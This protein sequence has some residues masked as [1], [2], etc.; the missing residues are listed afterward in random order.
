MSNTQLIMLLANIPV[1]GV[2]IYAAANFRKFE[3]ELRIFSGF[4]FANMLI[5]VVSS[6]MNLLSINNLPLLHIYTFC[7]GLSLL[8]FYHFI[9]RKYV[10]SSIL[11]WL[12]VAYALF[13]VLDSLFFEDLFTFNSLALTVL[14]VLIIILS[15]STFN[16]FLID[17][18]KAEQRE[19]INGL[20]WINSGLF[21]YFST[22]L[23]LYYFGDQLMDALFPADVGRMAWIP[24]MFFIVIMYICF[25]I[26]LW[27]SRKQ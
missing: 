7:T 9:L 20:L 11:A 1:A 3:K 17:S 4:L 15:L 13:S 27:K 19:R 25:F 21:V 14:S 10:S 5:Q 26:G 24:H 12:A 16:L 2:A 23:L 6:A 8:M 18:V 22:N